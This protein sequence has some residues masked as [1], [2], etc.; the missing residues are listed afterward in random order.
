VREGVEWGCD[1]ADTP[2]DLIRSPLRVD[3]GSSSSALLAGGVWNEFGSGFD[4]STSR[5]LGGE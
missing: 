4:V 5:S 3:R 2:L 1:V